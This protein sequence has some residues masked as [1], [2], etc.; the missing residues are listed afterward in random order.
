MRSKGKIAT[1]NDDKG[2][3]FIAPLDGGQQVFIHVNAFGNPDRRPEV[4]DVVTYAL[5]KD[6]QGRT[7]A[8]KATFP[9]E[10]LAKESQKKKGKGSTALA[11]IFFAIVGASVFVTDLPLLV[12]IYYLV[13]SLVSFIAYGID[14]WAALRGRWRTAE[15]TLHLVALIGGWPGAL[16]AQQVFRHKTRKEGFRTVFWATVILNCTAFAWIHTELGQT[17]LDQVLSSRQGPYTDAT[18]LALSL[19]NVYHRESEQA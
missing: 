12:P 9:G 13:L 4:G 7:H 5:A 6:K 19:G 8:T 15:G 10:K 18:P 17:Q 14:K 11:W 3:G 16:I 2:F 1:W